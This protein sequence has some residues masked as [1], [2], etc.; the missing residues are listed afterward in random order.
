M[1]RGTN[2]GLHV[3][4]SMWDS[5]V[6]HDRFQPL[7]MTKCK[8][9]V[10]QTLQHIMR[11]LYTFRQISNQHGMQLNN[12]Q[13]AAVVQTRQKMARNLLTENK[14]QTCGTQYISNWWKATN[15]NSR[16]NCQQRPKQTSTKQSNIIRGYHMVVF[17]S[18]CISSLIQPRVEPRADIDRQLG[19]IW[20]QTC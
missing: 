15:G 7:N 16:A 20:K 2:L 1:Y 8:W 4:H 5:K 11:N 12:R 3:P 17:I 14:N 13:V 6:I 19:L 10:R 9:T 18:A